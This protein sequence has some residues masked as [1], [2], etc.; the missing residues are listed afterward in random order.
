MP[1]PPNTISTASA[2]LV[3]CVAAKVTSFAGNPAQASD[4]LTC[5]PSRMMA[6]RE[7]FVRNIA[8]ARLPHAHQK[9]H[10][11][12]QLTVSDASSRIRF[13][14]VQVRFVDQSLTIQAEAHSTGKAEPSSKLRKVWDGHFRKCDE[15]IA[16]QP[17]CP[18]HRG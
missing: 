15:H 18:G 16:T 3:G 4:G 10:C 14:R 1:L 17:A 2:E 13:R 7:A 5:G 6:V 12:A 8:V 11:S 9:R